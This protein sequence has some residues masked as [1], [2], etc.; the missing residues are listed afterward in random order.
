MSQ[1]L[2]KLAG[3]VEFIMILRKMYVK[4]NIF[5]SLPWKPGTKYGHIAISENRGTSNQSFL[6]EMG[7]TEKGKVYT[8][9]LI[10]L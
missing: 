4:L 7:K 6:Q 9:L 3:Y 8:I 2:M 1:I 5:L 10:G